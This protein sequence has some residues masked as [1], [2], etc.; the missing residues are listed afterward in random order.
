MGT[1]H[2]SKLQDPGIIKSFKNVKLPETRELAQ[3]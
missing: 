3:N 1:S 2:K